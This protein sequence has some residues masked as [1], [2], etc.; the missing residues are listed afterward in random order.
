GAL[1][2]YDILYY[3]MLVILD[4][5]RADRSLARFTLIVSQLAFAG[6][7]IACHIDAL[8][9]APLYPGRVTPE[10]I[11][12][13]G[14]VVLVLM[15]SG[16]IATLSFLLIDLLAGRVQRREAELR[17]L[18]LSLAGRVEEQVALLR[19]S[20]DLRHYLPPGLADAILRGEP[21]SARHN[22]RRITVVRVDCP[23]I[24][25]AADET[26]PEEFAFLLNAL[27]AVIADRAAEQGGV[28][29]RFSTGGAQ[30]LFGALWEG[31]TENSGAVA[32]SMFAR[33][34]LSS[35]AELARRCQS[36]GIEAVPRG[37]VAVHQGFATVGSFGSPS[38]L[39]FTAVGPVMEA[40]LRLRDLTP[41]GSI[42]ISAPVETALR[43]DDP[44]APQPV[45]FG[46]PVTLPG[47][48]HAVRLF[49]LQ[50]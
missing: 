16:G 14:L 10:L 46:E 36:A 38:R 22:R 11:H 3:P 43:N 24:A 26:D 35:I 6:V 33:S 5:L 9:Y 17:Q 23:V 1:T 2:S 15:V 19:R 48:R 40:T 30:V 29:D 34:V 44:S 32:A 49:Q 45:P 4:R 47:A 42:V 21:D 50:V 20:A 18:G 28:V 27:Y 12:D 8:P 39:E 25:D 37:R 41:I 7:V 13:R 31:A